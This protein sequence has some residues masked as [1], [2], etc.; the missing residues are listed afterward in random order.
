MKICYP[1]L[2]YYPAEVGGPANTIFRLN[3]CLGKKGFDSIVLSTKYGVKST[4]KVDSHFY[5]KFNIQVRFI[6]GTL[7]SF[8][9]EIQVI[10]NKDIDVI[11]FSSLFFKPTLFYLIV[12]LFYG[13]KIVIS[14]RGEL[15][16][17]ALMRNQFK[18]RIYTGVLRL[19]KSCVYFHSTNSVETEQVISFFPRSYVIEIPNYI[20]VNSKLEVEIKKQF[21]FLGRINPIKNIDLLIK[22]FAKLPSKYLKTFKLVIAGEAI[23]DY[24]KHYLQELESLVRTLRLENVIKFLGG[25]YGN[26]KERLLAESYCLVLPSKSENFGNVVLEAL[27]QGTPVIASENTPWKK[28]NTSKSG[29][30]ISLDKGVLADKIEHLMG[31]PEGEY[32]TFRENA[33]KLAKYEFDIE[34]NIHKWID[35]YNSLR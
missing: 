2:C 13:K 12:G 29:F 32:M 6:S 23:L 14:P 26:R 35:F 4:K 17:A 28:L 34:V 11:H 1:V 20:E 33:F 24:E 10:K 7:L 16:Q 27:S 3:K 31:L 22:S 9:K 19:F 18:K 5:E 30:C 15:Y 8:I 21:L 25:V